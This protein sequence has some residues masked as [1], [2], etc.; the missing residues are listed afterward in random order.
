MTGSYVIVSTF[1]EEEVWS[2]WKFKQNG[3]K[4]LYLCMCMYTSVHHHTSF[5]DWC[6]QGPFQS[7]I[8]Q[9]TQ[10]TLILHIVRPPSINTHLDTLNMIVVI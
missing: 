1:S 6:F 7:Y 3:M 5:I 9:Y 10:R 2:A 8:M 4:V